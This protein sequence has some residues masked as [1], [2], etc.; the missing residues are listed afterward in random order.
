MPQSL[1]YAIHLLV[2]DHNTIIKK[3]LV[4]SMQKLGKTILNTQYQCTQKSYP[5]EAGSLFF[6]QKKC[7]ISLFINKY[8][9]QPI[10]LVLVFREDSKKEV[11]GGPQE[12][13]KFAPGS[14]SLFGM[15]PQVMYVLADAWT[16]P[17]TFSHFYRQ[18]HSIFNLGPNRLPTSLK[19]D[20]QVHILQIYI[21][22]L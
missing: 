19:V 13:E 8:V 4:I 7:E 21:M 3:S 6:F 5:Q 15:L 2:S 22:G 17:F 9:K 10:V 20:L 11:S 14:L 12:M 1:G 16:S 18:R